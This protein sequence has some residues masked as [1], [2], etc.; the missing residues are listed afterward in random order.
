MPRLTPTTIS[1]GETAAAQVPPE[2]VDRILLTHLHADHVA[3]LRDFP[4]VEVIYFEEAYAAV[5][6]LSPFKSATSGFVPEL[7][8]ADFVSRSRTKS[9]ATCRPIPYQYMPFTHGWDIF[10]DGSL[11]GV[12]LPGHMYGQMGLFVQT[13][14]GPRFSLR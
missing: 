10:G 7:L 13:A 4:D 6:D 3:G 5:R 12:H 2:T 11:I 14:A 9:A 8:P 1:G